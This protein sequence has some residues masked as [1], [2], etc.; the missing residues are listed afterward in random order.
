M[1]FFLYKFIGKIWKKV[2]MVI[3]ISRI[4]TPV[5]LGFQAPLIDHNENKAMDYTRYSLYRDHKI[6]RVVCTANIPTY[7]LPVPE[8]CTI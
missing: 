1:I 6:T 2:R 4:I 3:S 7:L 8:L 5:F